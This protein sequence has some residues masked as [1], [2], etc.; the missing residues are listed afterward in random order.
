MLKTKYIYIITS[1]FLLTSCGENVIYVPKPPTY[2]KVDVPEATY[3]KF[4]DRCPYTFDI[5]S[6]YNVKEIS[7]DNCHKDIDLGVLN[8]VVHFS[9]IQMEAPLSEY[10]NFANDKIDEHK[11]MATA[12]EDKQILRP[13]KKVYGTFFSLEGNV[14]SPF[15]FYL[16]DSTDRFVSAVVYFNSAPNYDSLK[17]TLDYVKTDLLRM[18]ESFEW[19]K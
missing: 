19:K 9:Y 15:Q 6:L 1:I 3:S 4:E 18:I 2:L 10:V 13:D 17:P 14:A 11:V 12:I 8:G 16:T 7:K 5:S